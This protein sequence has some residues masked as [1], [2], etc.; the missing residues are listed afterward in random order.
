MIKGIAIVAR[1]AHHHG[2]PVAIA[3]KGD[4]RPEVIRGLPFEGRS[5]PGQTA[6]R[7]EPG[8]PHPSGADEVKDKSPPL[9]G[10]RFRGA[11][12]VGVFGIVPVG[13]ADHDPVADH[14]D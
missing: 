6:V 9:I 1:R 12:V 5:G 4:R 2:R 11:I 8:D 13:G 10:D 3:I 7:G 14:G